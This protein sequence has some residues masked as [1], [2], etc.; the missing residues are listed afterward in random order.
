MPDA[1]SSTGSRRDHLRHVRRQAELRTMKLNGWQRLW[2]VM[3]V[4]WAL[5]VV[6]VGYAQWPIAT[7]S[8]AT[9]LLPPERQAA[10]LTSR[11]AS[12]DIGA[13]EGMFRR[14][15]AVMAARHG[16]DRDPDAPEQ[17]YDYRA[18]YRARAT[19]NLLGRWP[20]EFKLS[21]RGDLAYLAAWTATHLGLFAIPLF[22]IYSLGLSLGWV[23]RGFDQTV[24]TA[25]APTPTAAPDS[26]APSAPIDHSETVQRPSSKVSVVIAVAL[27][28]KLCA[29]T[30]VAPEDATLGYHAAAFG[31]PLV[32]YSVILMALAATAAK[33]RN[34][35]KEYRLKLFSWLFLS[36]V[37]FD[38][39]A[40]GVR[41]SVVDP[42][43]Q[44]ALEHM[45]IGQ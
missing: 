1:P 10:R 11:L 30:L 37:L 13:D 18:A 3:A 5:V 29:Y 41:L 20:S 26:V 43:V 19:P 24:D 27:F 42:A 36:A 14:W 28:L 9:T 4:L 40:V 44:R 17:L 45:Q 2:A 23:R 21:V 39:V 12:R 15:Y 34:K 8:L 32:S 38:V 33:V 7:D 35:S 31:F 6:A 22:F 25:S 16:L